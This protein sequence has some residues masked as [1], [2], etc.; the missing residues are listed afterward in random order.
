MLIHRHDIVGCDFGGVICDNHKGRGHREFFTPQ[1][2]KNYCETRN[3]V[4]HAF[5]TLTKIIELVGPEK[6][7]I[8]SRCTKPAEKVILAWLKHH[9]F[10][11]KTGASPE[12]IRFCRERS[13]K[14][15][16]VDE[17]GITVFIDD[18]WGVLRVM[19]A[20]VTRI[21][22]NALSEEKCLAVQDNKTFFHCGRWT[23]LRRF[24]E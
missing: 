19:K 10:F 15:E 4:D 3:P 9:D 11:S 2:I 21:L 12:N 7:M 6:F 13:D 5:E 22:F 24:I 20:K 18:R 23:D 1:E 17:L 14:A 8:V 16:L